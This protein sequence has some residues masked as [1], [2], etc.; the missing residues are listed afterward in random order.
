M[1]TQFNI[2]KGRA[3]E[4]VNQI[5]ANA[6]ANSGLLVILLKTT[7]TDAV[8]K[9]YANLALLLAEAGNVEADFTGYARKPLTDADLAAPIVDNGADTQYFAIPAV[10][11]TSA[12]GTLDNTLV[13]ALIVYCPDVTAIVDAN[14]V[15]IS[16][17]DVAETTNGNNLNVNAG[18]ILTSS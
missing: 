6:P 5:R 2:A 4:F 9:D 14:C 7:E 18:T 11:W 13:K 3:N 16:A 17:H 12:G 10:Q 15:P 1:S 8:L